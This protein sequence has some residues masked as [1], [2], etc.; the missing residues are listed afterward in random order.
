MGGEEQNLSTTVVTMAIY[1]HV[2]VSKKELTK[3]H[4]LPICSSCL[5]DISSRS[6]ENVLEKK[7][8]SVQRTNCGKSILN[9]APVVQK[10][11]MAILRINHH[12]V[13][14]Y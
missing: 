12:P 2:H 3:S 11:D 7:I 1:Y 9:V 5:L 4:F 8:N 6:D 13:D 10:L 14:K